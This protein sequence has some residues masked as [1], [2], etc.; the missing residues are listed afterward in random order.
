MARFTFLDYGIFVV[1]LLAS[2]LIG[3]LFVKEQR[4]LKDYFLAGQS[5]NSIVVA[6]SVLAALFSGITYLGAPAEV[7]A[8]GFWFVLIALSFFIATPVTNLLFLPFFY[9]AKFFT[10][11]QFLEERFSVGIR[12]LASVLFI[13][14]TVI[15]LALATYAPALALE[16]VTGIP[17]WLTISATGLLTTFYT[18]LGGMKAVIWTDVMQFVVLFGG[19]LAII[20]LAVSYVPGGAQGVY[21][22][23]RDAGKYAL[24]FSLDPTIRVTFWGLII[25]GAFANLVQ[26]AT[27]QVSVQ[28]YLT[29]TDMATARRSLWIK[30][31]LTLPVVSVFYLTGLVLYAFYQTKGDPV[32]SGLVASVDQI[33]PYF[34]VTEMPAGMPGLLV[35]A[36]YAASM[37]TISAGLNS[38]TSSSLVD[39]YQRLY[40]PDVEEESQ[41]KLARYITLGYG[42]IVTA[43]AFVVSALGTI[44]QASNTIFGLV[45]GPLLGLFLL[46]MLS[47]RANSKGAFLGWLA[48]FLVLMPIVY[49]T[50]VS[51]LWYGLIGCLVTWGLGWVFSLLLSDRTKSLK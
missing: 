10:A 24:S 37:S 30:L 44:L 51:F 43:L 33:L 20:I 18:T 45:G 14:R 1:Y 46:G 5:M 17:L 23:G 31:A 40:K 9:N 19:Q 4:N 6:I 29:A 49:L 47:K 12:T 27:D 39:I 25:G 38:M 34:V 35:A 22:I 41:L 36:I 2:V 7:Y 15:W 42:V 50:K 13:S 32:A 28:R 11:Y 48:G 16:Q 8:N 21:E 26:M 3:L